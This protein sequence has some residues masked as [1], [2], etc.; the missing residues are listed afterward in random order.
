MSK[1]LLT[2]EIAPNIQDNHEDLELL[3]VAIGLDQDDWDNWTLLTKN[4]VQ[5]VW[6]PDD[7]L[8][9]NPKR[10]KMAIEKKACNALLLKVNHFGSVAS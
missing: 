3:K 10:I 8:V 7:L 1:M 9:T 2:S 4:T 5:I 6:D